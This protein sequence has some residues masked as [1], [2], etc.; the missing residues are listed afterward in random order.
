MALSFDLKILKGHLLGARMYH[1]I[2]VC[3][4]LFQWGHEKK[5]KE[6]KQDKLLRRK[7]FRQ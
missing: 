3:S 1:L 6:I 7:I 4:P 5:Q 2:I